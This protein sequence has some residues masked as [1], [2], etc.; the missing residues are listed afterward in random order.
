MCPPAQSLIMN[1][2]RERVEN[3][4]RSVNYCILESILLPAA[5]FADFYNSA[6]LSQNCSHQGRIILD[7][8]LLEN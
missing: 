6:G 3:I 2:A 4:V 8:I 7:L 1:T 5:V